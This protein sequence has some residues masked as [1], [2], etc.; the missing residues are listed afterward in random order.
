MRN[1]CSP[2]SCKAMQ[3]SCGTRND[4]ERVT[5]ELTDLL[6]MIFDNNLFAE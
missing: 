4:F 1:P 6:R 5:G 3:T 2:R